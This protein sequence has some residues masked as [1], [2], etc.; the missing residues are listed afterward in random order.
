MLATQASVI[1]LWSIEKHEIEAALQEFTLRSYCKVNMN[2]TLSK[3][4]LSNR[5]P[6]AT[7]GERTSLV[8][9][10][11][12]H[13]K[14]G[15]LVKGTLQ[16]ALSLFPFQTSQIQSIWRRAKEGVLDP[17]KKVDLSS[18]KK[19]RCGRKRK[20]ETADLAKMSEI[21]FSQR[22]TLRS[23]G[24]ALEIPV[25]S[26]WR[27]LKSGE[28]VRHSSSLKPLLTERNKEERFNFCRSFVTDNGFFESMMNYIHIDE[29]WFY[30]TKINE[31]FYLLPDESPPD[32][33]TKSKRFIT[34]VMF[35]A[36]VARPRY[37]HHR[38]QV[39]DGK[40]GIWPFIYQEAAKR[41]SRNRCKGTME[42]KVVT[43]VTKDVIRQML[44]EKLIPAV[45]SKMPCV[46]KARIIIQQDNAKP[47]CAVDDPLL[48]GALIEGGFRIKFRCQ[49][50][51]SPDLNV[52]DLGFFNSIQSLQHKK[53]PKSIDDLV[54]AV[55][56]S[57]EELKSETL[58]DV[59]LSLQM[60]ME[61][62]MK[63]DGGNSYKLGHMKKQ[64]LRRKH[65][66]PANLLCDP[67]ALVR[68]SSDITDDSSTIAPTA[69]A[70]VATTMDLADTV[71]AL[72][73]HS[74]ETSAAPDGSKLHSLCETGEKVSCGYCGLPATAAHFCSICLLV[75]HA[76]CGDTDG[77]EGYGKPVK[78]FRCC[79]S[80]N[81]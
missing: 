59:F 40:I 52:L 25:T 62:T 15:R 63:C 20:Y 80:T 81:I 64:Q 26:L 48:V 78:C 18:R 21:P 71:P 50:P 1:V 45:K 65:L 17:N 75:V 51:N 14:N 32:R 13:H 70:T 22:T 19:G 68:D 79:P 44:L 4:S 53:V 54:A 60:A 33:T 72:S 7:D 69:P 34:K 74:T 3:R 28:I 46:E 58:D 38:K 67:S 29:K 27:L 43:S 10:L 73:G 2:E 55:E 12:Q 56:D 61:S 76:I 36:A 16:E 77:D 8:V 11:S 41:N 47:H 57:F 39:F 30:M 66:L 31:N 9:F 6:N 23:L 37:D 5:K 49:P 24:C 35:L 42:T